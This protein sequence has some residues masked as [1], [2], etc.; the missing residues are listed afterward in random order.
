MSTQQI[1]QW[2]F[3][4]LT[5]KCVKFEFTE[6]AKNNI[7]KIGIDKYQ[8]EVSLRL[9]IFR[10]RNLLSIRIF[11]DLVKSEGNKEKIASLESLNE[12]NILDIDKV[13]PMSAEGHLVPDSVATQLFS[14]S[15]ANVRGM[16]AV[17]LEDSIYDNAILPVMDVS[18]M[19]PKKPFSFG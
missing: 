14:I 1:L 5:C 12:F 6:F 7:D 17:K 10:D 15:L 4:I 11:S 13:I 18:Q 8:F 9:D 16:Y 3:S 2:T 19:I